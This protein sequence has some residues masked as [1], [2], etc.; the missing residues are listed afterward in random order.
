M[1]HHETARRNPAFIP[2]WALVVA[3]LAAVLAVAF[4][5]RAQAD[6]EPVVGGGA[7]VGNGFGSPANEG[8]TAMAVFN[9]QLFVAAGGETGS[10]FVMRSSANGVSW[11][12]VTDDGFGDAANQVVLAMAVFDGYLYAGTTNAATGAEIWRLSNG[13]T[14]EQV[15]SD[16]F[17]SPATTAVVA[18]AVFDG[19]LFAGTENQSIG[20]GIYRSPDGTSWI[21]TVIGGFGDA[22]NRA[23][24][25]LAGYGSR[26]YAGTFKESTLFNQ[27]GEL[28]WTE[29]FVTWNGASAPGFGD[30]YNV[31]I[32]SLEP[33]DGYLFAGT[34]QPNFLFGDGCEVWRWDGA[35]W[36][37]VSVP[38]F[39]SSYSTTAVR[40]A[41]HLDEL[42]VGVDHQS[43]GGA[44]LFRYLGPMSWLP[45]TDDGFG[46]TGNSAIASL[47]SFNG[48][49]YG[50][51]LN[52]AEGC[53][54]WRQAGAA[55]ADGF[56]SGDTSA[57][58]A[59]VP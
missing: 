48:S 46:D 32:I 39:G 57:W 45:E 11:D 12:V 52:Q 40:L 13:T 26:F 36:I 37:M 4:P 38:G 51:T 42:Y 43:S 34:S 58:S 1:A 9:G 27:P 3:G 21:P 20:G 17:G 25:S 33:F 50:G 29:D 54:V 19:V 10:A 16:G 28:W 30:T 41:E 6:W 31:A 56:E 47:A 2:G 8:A 18:L 59:T 55:F 15:N 53:E 7:A 22:A 24:A 14:W 35:T 5:A 44:K 23:V 49:L